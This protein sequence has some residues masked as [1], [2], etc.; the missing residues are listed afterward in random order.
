MVGVE[1][2]AI[3]GGLTRPEEAEESAHLGLWKAPRWGVK[4]GF[5]G[6]VGSQR[7]GELGLCRGEGLLGSSGPTLGLQWNS[8]V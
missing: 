8:R 7:T 6:D 3:G 4:L 5:E 2:R 1:K